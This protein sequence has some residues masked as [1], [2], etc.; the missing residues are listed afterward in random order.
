MKQRNIMKKK[1]LNKGKKWY[2]VYKKCIQNIQSVLEIIFKTVKCYKNKKDIIEKKKYIIYIYIYI[3]IICV[4]IFLNCIII[5][6]RNSAYI[7]IYLQLI[8]EG[9]IQCEKYRLHLNIILGTNIRNK[10]FIL[11][12]FYYC[13]LLQ[14]CVH[15]GSSN[16]RF[17][18]EWFIW[19]KSFQWIIDLVQYLFTKRAASILVTQIFRVISEK[20]EICRAIHMDYFNA[21]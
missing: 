14:Q 19:V 9:S 8:R 5:F 10:T 16:I 11:Q 21:L 1:L 18:N 13:Y 17:E 7:H 3:Y 20:S 15:E 6:I 12:M 4:T 2:T